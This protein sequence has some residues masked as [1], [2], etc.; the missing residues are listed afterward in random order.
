[1]TAGSKPHRCFN[2]YV[3]CADD[4]AVTTSFKSYPNLISDDCL[5]TVFLMHVELGNHMRLRVSVRRGGGG[6]GMGEY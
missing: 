5:N 6:E 1:M 2:R 4:N 3:H